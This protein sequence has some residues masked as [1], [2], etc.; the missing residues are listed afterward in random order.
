MI[1]TM[2]LTALVA[3]V[4]AGCGSDSGGGA[5]GGGGGVKYEFECGASI[6]SRG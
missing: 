2:V 4:A 5:S 3:C 1:K 6:L